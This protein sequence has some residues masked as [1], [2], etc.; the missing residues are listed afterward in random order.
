MATPERP[1]GKPVVRSERTCARYLV[2]ARRLLSQVRAT[3]IGKTLDDRRLLARKSFMGWFTTRLAAEVS[4][5]TWRRY[6]V[7]ISYAAEQVGVSPELVVRLRKATPDREAKPGR[8]R[9]SR[10]VQ[11]GMSVGELRSL[12]SR[13]EARSGDHPGRQL[14][15]DL[16]FATVATGLRAEEWPHARVEPDAKRYALVLATPG[17]DRRVMLER[18]SGW[19]LDRIRAVCAA[20]AQPHWPAQVQAVTARLR[21]M[22]ASRMARGIPWLSLESA[23]GQYALDH[24]RGVSTANQAAPEPGR[25]RW[26]DDEY[27]FRDKCHFT[28][29]GVGTLTPR[30][31]EVALQTA[32][33]LASLPLPRP[34]P[35]PATQMEYTAEASRLLRLGGPSAVWEGAAHTKRVSV[36]RKRRAALRWLDGKYPKFIAK[37]HAAGQID[38]PKGLFHLTVWARLSR[39]MYHEP[40]IGALKGMMPGRARRKSLRS[41][42]ALLPEG[43]Q[44]EL[45]SA[46]PAEWRDAMLVQAV[47]GC[48]PAE[49]GKGVQVVVDD[50]HLAIAILG[51]KVTRRSGWYERVMLWARPEGGWDPLLERL[52][53]G[54]T[55]RVELGC[56]PGAYYQRIVRAARRLWPQLRR[57]VAPYS[58]RHAVAALAKCYRDPA[59]VAR[60]LGHRSPVTQ[61]LYGDRRSATGGE[62]LVPDS[63]EVYD[64]PAAAARFAGGDSGS[65][66][67]SETAEQPDEFSDD[68]QSEPADESPEPTDDYPVPG[69]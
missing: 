4:P 26:I 37:L 62:G 46:L 36:L 51:A 31:R 28:P 63:V 57:P 7:A 69:A 42:T 33:E 3:G 5:S 1:P 29:E 45:H 30:M 65:V 21:R 11:P 23:V 52:R 40:D 6:R 14:T 38:T 19:V 12:R 64:L 8:V 32:L 60:M 24:A 48:R 41:V 54:G 44:A 20:A 34:D 39:V 49:L 25:A 17:A 43:W 15:R 67:R 58:L 18:L 9:H 10:P 66:P 22:G 50:H 59:D 55:R 68:S 27:H 2:D 61:A 56:T 35:S 53:S 16:L 13:L 47:T